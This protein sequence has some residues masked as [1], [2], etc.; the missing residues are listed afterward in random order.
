MR[1]VEGKCT[2]CGANVKVDT[3]KDA[4][5]CIF[6][7]S[8][9][10]VEKAINLFNTTNNI[11]ANTDNISS[12][13][14]ADFKIRAGKL[15][16]YNGAK[17]DVM[18]PS[19]V[20]IVGYGAFAWCN[21]L[22]SIVIPDCVNEIEHQAFIGCSGLQNII[23]PDSV[24]KIPHGLFEGCTS[25]QNARIPV[26]LKVGYA[27]E[28]NWTIDVEVNE[29]QIPIT[30]DNLSIDDL[31]VIATGLFNARVEQYGLSQ[32][33]SAY[34]GST[35][36]HPKI[37]L[38]SVNTALRINGTYFFKLLKKRIQN[39][40]NERKKWEMQGLCRRCGGKR[41]FI[42]RKCKACGFATY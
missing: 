33:A 23:I 32:E 41:S 3:S 10:I 28:Y 11:R 38:G 30:F 15:E 36:F 25:L 13:D 24:I 16:K 40:E 8:A 7:G 19:N 27:E 18:I 35:P 39:I 21:G 42:G 17:V 20:S 6:C 14:S 1:L 29:T 5:I 26:G 4:A 22:K 37:K 12:G 34:L 2:N 31:Y 9:F